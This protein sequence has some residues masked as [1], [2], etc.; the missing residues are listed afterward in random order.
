M[1]ILKDDFN[2]N[3]VENLDDHKEKKRKILHSDFI[4]YQLIGIK[5]KRFKEFN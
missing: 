4:T 1:S 3:S 5:I 2:K